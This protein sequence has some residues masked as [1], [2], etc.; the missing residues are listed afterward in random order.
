MSKT[1]SKQ[2]EK[3]EN[4]RFST[5]IPKT[6]ENPKKSEKEIREKKPK[7]KRKKRKKKRKKKN[8]KEIQFRQKILLS[9]AEIAD[10]H[11][12]TV[13]LVLHIDRSGVNKKLVT[14][15][16]RRRFLLRRKKARE[17]E[18]RASRLRTWW[19]SRLHSL[20]I[21]PMTLD[22]ADP[23]WTACH[24]YARGAVVRLAYAEV[25][26]GSV[27]GEPTDAF[28]LRVLE[29]AEELASLTPAELQPRLD[30]YGVR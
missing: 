29:R 1:R 26:E 19:R 21:N 16:I 27:G 18:V 9:L 11:T 6:L 2:E 22:V 17:R 14:E 20:G 10:W 13:S 15:A 23:L 4:L 3:P 28:L 5:K 24:R 12:P 8:V 30:T 25:S 7:R